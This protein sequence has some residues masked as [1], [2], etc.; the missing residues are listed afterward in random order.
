N[1]PEASLTVQ[2]LDLPS[3]ITRDQSDARVGLLQSLENDFVSTRPGLSTQSHQAAY[4]RAL[5]LMHSKASKAFNLE[6]E[7]VQV[8]DGYGR[9][10]F[11]QGCLLARRLVERQVPFVEVTLD[12]WDTHQDNFNQVKRLSETL[13]TAW[14]ALMKDLQQRGLLDT[15]LIVWMG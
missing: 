7:P 13:D 3:G 6:E 9:N 10:G 12:G 5:R 1:Q 11:G 8:R 4:Q 14:A 15:T 2:D